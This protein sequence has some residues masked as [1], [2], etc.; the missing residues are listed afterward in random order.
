V[1]K[2]LVVA[3]LGIAGVGLMVML[4]VPLGRLPGDLYLRR[5]GFSFYIP[6][7]TSILLSLVLTAA[8]AI[9]RR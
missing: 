2:V 7:T 8:L 5:G 9:L 6:V 4:G 1:G 3:G